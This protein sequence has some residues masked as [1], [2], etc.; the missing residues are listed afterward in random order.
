MMFNL[1]VLRIA[2]LTSSKLKQEIMLQ[3]GS[4]K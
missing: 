4:I 2:H 3:S 1:Y